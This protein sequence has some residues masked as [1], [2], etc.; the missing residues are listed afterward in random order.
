MRIAAHVLLLLLVGIQLLAFRLVQQQLAGDPDEHDAADEPHSRHHQE[1]RHDHRE[2]DPHGDG[3]SAAPQNRL[4]SLMV[5]QPVGRHGNHD[6]V[7][8]RQHDV[9]EDDLRDFCKNYE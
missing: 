5:G 6:G 4:F 8:S 7:V 1:K 2:H 3:D 9:D